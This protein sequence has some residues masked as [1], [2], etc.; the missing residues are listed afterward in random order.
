MHLMKRIALTL[1]LLLLSIFG[2]S[3]L[4]AQDSLA[5]LPELSLPLTNTKMVIAHCMTHIIRYEGREYEDGANPKYYPIT[6][7]VGGTSQVHVMS[8]TLLQHATL[9]QA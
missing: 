5:N 2:A 3:N 1:S 9:D 8:D 4:F 6:D 7:P